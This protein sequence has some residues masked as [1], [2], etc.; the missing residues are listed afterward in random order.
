[1]V[2]NPVTVSP[3][4]SVSELV[5][6]YIY[7]Y[8]FKMFPVVAGDVLKGCVTT[9]EVKEVPKDQWKEKTVG[10]IARTC[11]PE[12]TVRPEVD[13]L[14]ALSLMSKTG[15]SRLM[16]TDG[17]KLVGIITLKDLMKFLSVKMDLDEESFSS[18]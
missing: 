2:I 8:H 7:Q 10:D 11:S 15:S 6:D 13:T 1:M 18:R 12:N 4:L 3:D 17:Q 5:D 14:D 16:V 9:R